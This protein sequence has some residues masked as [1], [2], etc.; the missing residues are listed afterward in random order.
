VTY[1]ND[2]RGREDKQHFGLV[3]QQLRLR[4]RVDGVFRR[5]LPLAEIKER[6]DLSLLSAPDTT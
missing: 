4:R 5:G 3:K 2:G 1:K 6:D